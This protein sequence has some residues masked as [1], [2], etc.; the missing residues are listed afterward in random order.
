VQKP[1]PA[2]FQAACRALNVA[3]QEAVYIGDDPWLDV[4]GAQ[5]A[6]LQAVW[7]NRIGCE[8]QRTLPLHIQPSAI[9]T[10]L[11]ELDQWLTG[12]IMVATSLGAR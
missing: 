1:D 12:R 6:G 4:D 11:F 8:P 5:K 9:C 3:P 7:I 10:T 2:I